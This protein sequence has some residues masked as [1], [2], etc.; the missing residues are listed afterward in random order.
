M[1]FKCA[2]GIGVILMLFLSSASAQTSIPEKLHALIYPDA[3]VTNVEKSAR[4][5]SYSYDVDIVAEGADYKAVV[6]FYREKTGKWKML[7]D[8][9]RGTSFIMMCHDGTHRFDISGMSREN[10]IMIRVSMIKK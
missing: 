4:G 8:V 10:K 5:G 2:I 6:S 3:K 7:R 9:N 1:K